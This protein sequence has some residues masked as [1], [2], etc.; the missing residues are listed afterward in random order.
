[1]EEELKINQEKCY[2][3]KRRLVL[4]FDYQGKNWVFY[5]EGW[6]EPY[7]KTLK[8]DGLSKDFELI[9]DY[10]HCIQAYFDVDEDR[11]L[12]IDRRYEHDNSYDVYFAGKHYLIGEEPT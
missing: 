3:D 6:S 10:K 12:F 1:M 11:K 5:Y 4:D 9:T 2:V 7:P 8:V